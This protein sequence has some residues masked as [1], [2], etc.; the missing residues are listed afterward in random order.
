M[1]ESYPC[2]ACGF[3]VF[4][5]PP[6]I[7]EICQVCGWEDDHVQLAHPMMRGGANSESLLEAQEAA[8]LRYPLSMREFDGETRDQYWRPLTSDE[9]EVASGCPRNGMQ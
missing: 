2:P 7:Y 8:L 5:G 4:S 6:G 9:A 3:L 1:D